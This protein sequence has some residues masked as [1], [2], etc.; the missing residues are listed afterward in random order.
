[1]EP[2]NASIG[3][4]FQRQR[5]HGHALVASGT[6]HGGFSGAS[7]DTVGWVITFTGT[8]ALRIADA[9]L[10]AFWANADGLLL[11]LQLGVRGIEPGQM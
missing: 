1:V 5:A 6:Y 3:C 4:G 7:P 2:L 11:V 10:V 9:Q 8:E